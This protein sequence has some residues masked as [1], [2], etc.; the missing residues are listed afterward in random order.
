MSVEELQSSELGTKE[1]WDNAYDMEIKNFKEFGD[2]GEIWFGE[3]CASRITKWLE[4]NESNKSESVVDLGC[5]NGML[6]MKLA[7]NG[8]KD[9]TG[10][11]YSQSAI[12]LAKGIAKSEEVSI[13]YQVW[14]IL[15]SEEVFQRKRFGV[16]LDKGTYDAISLSPE[17]RT[18][19]RQKYISSVKRILKPNGLLIITSCNWTEEEL[20][21][22]FCPAGFEAVAL[23]PAPQFQFGGSSGNKVTSIVFKNI[24]DN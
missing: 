14:D 18:Q 2:V 15:S 6:L 21:A 11:D 4:S 23:I 5:G 16:A 24:E 3:G 8:W 13:S 10:V 17:D 7:E 19:C 22:T 20:K 9:L 12:D 1:Y